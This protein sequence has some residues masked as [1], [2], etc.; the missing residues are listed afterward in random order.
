V[1]P[2]GNA[3]ARSTSTIPNTG[4]TFRS[5]RTDSQVST[6]APNYPVDVSSDEQPASDGTSS[7]TSSTTTGS[8]AVVDH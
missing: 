7:G 6:V 1:T 2:T 5:S 3:A 4:E 8:A